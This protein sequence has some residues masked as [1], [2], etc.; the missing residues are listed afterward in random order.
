M[1]LEYRKKKSNRPDEI[2]YLVSSSNR[3]RGSRI[4]EGWFSSNNS[5]VILLIQVLGI[6]YGFSCK[7][8]RKTSKMK[9][10]KLKNEE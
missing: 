8:K 7:E 6:I 9:C 10:K 1:V 5:N 3:P 4:D 2:V